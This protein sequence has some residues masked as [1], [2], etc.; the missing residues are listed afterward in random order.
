MFQNID[1]TLFIWV[2]V[3]ACLMIA[4]TIFGVAKAKSYNEFKW[5]TLKD[6]LI[7]Y[8]L[9]LL[10]VAFVFLA[11]LLVPTF[12]FN[13]TGLDE[14]ITI[15]LL[16]ISI[17]IAVGTKY[18]ISVKDNLSSLFNIKDEDIKEAKSQ[19]DNGIGNDT[20]TIV[21]EG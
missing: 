13:V 17:A 12:A 6:G 11:G 5:T 9:I 4:N 14:G 15:N 21:E 10:G 8:L 18:V 16:L 7:K 2:G 20:D 3:D 1:W 19:Y